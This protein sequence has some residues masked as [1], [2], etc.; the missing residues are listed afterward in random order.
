MRPVRSQ[1]RCPARA[2]VLRSSDLSSCCSLESPVLVGG[3]VGAGS[4]GIRDGHHGQAHCGRELSAACA[5]GETGDAS[6]ASS[7]WDGATC[8][9]AAP[10]RGPAIRVCLHIGARRAI[11]HGGLCEADGAGPSRSRD[12]VRDRIGRCRRPR[13]AAPCKSAPRSRQMISGRSVG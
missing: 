13:D 5:A 7:K 12:Q 11:Q 4:N 1:A 3:V 2:M 10:A 9:A 6:H 8:P